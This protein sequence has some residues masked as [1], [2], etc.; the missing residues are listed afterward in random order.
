MV[1]SNIYSCDNHQ[2]YLVLNGAK[3][4]QF[5]SL[6]TNSDS[7]N[8]KGF[9]MQPSK[10]VQFNQKYNPYAII[11]EQRNLLLNNNNQKITKTNHNNIHTILQQQ[12]NAQNAA[13]GKSLQSPQKLAN[14]EAHKLR[15]TPL[16]NAD[17]PCSGREKLSNPHGSSGSHNCVN[18]NQAARK[19]E[20]EL[21]LDHAP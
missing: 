14:I 18:C 13:S 10:V 5:Q 3:N 6:I 17:N 21:E 19:E 2:N 9:Q 1:N 8:S 20:T 7:G 16:S 15:N 12:L 4:N 11:L